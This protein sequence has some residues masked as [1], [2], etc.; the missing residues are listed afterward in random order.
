MGLAWINPLYLAGL[1]L[2]AL[3]VLIHLVQK[4][5]GQGARFPSLMFLKQIPQRQKKRLEIRHWLLL[6]LRCLLLLLIVLA[7]ARPFLPLATAPGT[8][9]PERADSIIVL[10]RSYS[11]HIADHWQ[12][13]LDQALL[14]VQQKQAQDRIGILLIDDEAELVSDLTSSVDDLRGALQGQAPGLRATH[15]PLAIEQAARLLAGSNASRKRIF[16]ISDFQAAA[17]STVARI[18]ADIDLQALPVKITRAANASITAATIEPSVRAAADEFALRVEI[19]NRATVPLDQQLTLTLDGRVL[20][21]RPLRLAPAATIT[22]T[23]DGLSV[24]DDLVRGIVSLGDD[25][26]ALDNRYFFVYSSRQ[27]LPLLIVEG[28][29]PRAN[30]SVFLQNALELARNPVFRVERRAFDALKAEDLPSWALII[31]NDVAIPPGTLADA[32]ADFVAA[33]GGLLVIAAAAP[34]QNWPTFLLPGRP[35]RIVESKQASAF[36]VAGFETGHPLTIGLGTRN[37]A[38]LSRARVF[39]YRDLQAGADD[40]VVARYNDGGAALLERQLGQGRVQVLTTTLDTF[41]ND[42]ALQP[43]FLPFLH[44][45]LRYLSAFESYSNQAEIGSIIDVMRYARALTGVDA[46]VAA[47]TRGPLLIES[48]QSAEIRVNRQS[49]L[50]TLAQ[51]GFY[52][53]HNATRAG[54]EVTLAANV[55][56][57]EANQQTLDLERFVREIMAAADPVATDTVLNNRQAAAYEQQQQLAYAILLAALA[58]MLIEALCANWISIRQSLRTR[59]TG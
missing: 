10:D 59:G 18:S 44:Q 47:E 8:L 5:H 24:S 23:F 34:Q 53:V 4:Q 21:R 30:Q 13:A 51:P 48:P 16:V 22:E 14:L 58:L 2:L 3:P 54:A 33:G 12:Q 1:L 49:P 20:E 17:V 39:N 45:D 25:A 50:L 27:Q 40:R 43:V 57:H 37:T 41:W 42:I 19:M 26:L 9:E 35:G 6:L 7:F 15:L 11:M 29:K 31:M 38:D 32:L 28:D 56:P 52:Q 36:S 55:D 46:V